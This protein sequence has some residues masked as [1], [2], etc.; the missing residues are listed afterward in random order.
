MRYERNYNVVLLN[1]ASVQ[2]SLKRKGSETQA[3]SPW[4]L[5]INFKRSTGRVKT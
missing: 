5:I 4:A 1:I 2:N 3:R